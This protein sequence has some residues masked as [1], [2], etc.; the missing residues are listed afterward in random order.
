MM[1]AAQDFEPEEFQRLTNFLECPPNKCI[2]SELLQI[3]YKF[4]SNVQKSL[5]SELSDCLMLRRLFKGLQSCCVPLVTF[6]QALL[7]NHFVQALAKTYDSLLLRDYDKQDVLS[8]LLEL[9]FLIE[10][11]SE[12]PEGKISYGK[13][14]VPR[15]LVLAPVRGNAVNLQRA[16]METLCALITR[17]LENQQAV[18]D[19]VLDCY[20]LF[21]VFLPK[22][23]D[24]HLQASIAEIL[25]RL[26]RRDAQL[27]DLI[28]DTASKVAILNIHNM[29]KP[30]LVFEL[31]KFV[32][33]LNESTGS[34]R[35]VHSFLVDKITVNGHEAT[36]E[37]K[38]ID[39]G[40]SHISCYI[41]KSGNDEAHI[42]DLLYQDIIKIHRCSLTDLEIVIQEKCTNPYFQQDVADHLGQSSIHLFFSPED[43]SVII[44]SVIPQIRKLKRQDFKLTFHDQRDQTYLTTPYKSPQRRIGIRKVS[45]GLR[46]PLPKAMAVA[47]PVAQEL[48]QDV[49]E[50]LNT[51]N[52]ENDVVNASD[53]KFKQEEDRQRSNVEKGQET[54]EITKQCVIMVKEAQMKDK[55]VVASNPREYGA[56]KAEADKDQYTVERIQE[57]H[58][59]MEQRAII[60][61]ETQTNDTILNICNQVNCGAKAHVQIIHHEPPLPP[62]YF[63][64]DIT[65]DSSDEMEPMLKQKD[66][67]KEKI[68]DLSPTVLKAPKT[69]E[70]NAKKKKVSP[71]DFEHDSMPI[72]ME[73]SLE[74]VKFSTLMSTKKKP[75]RR[76]KRIKLSSQQLAHTLNLEPSS[77]QLS[78][79]GQQSSI[80]DR[81]VLQSKDPEE[82]NSLD[83]KDV[84]LPGRNIQVQVE[85][86]STTV[87]S[88]RTTIFQFQGSESKRPKNGVSDPIETDSD[89]H[90]TIMAK[91]FTVPYDQKRT[92]LARYKIKKQ[93][94]PL[95]Q[96]ILMKTSCEYQ[97]TASKDKSGTLSNLQLRSALRSTIISA[98]GQTFGSMVAPNKITP[99]HRQ[100]YSKKARKDK[101]NIEHLGNKDTGP[102][103][104]RLVD[105]FMCFGPL[106][107]VPESPAISSPTVK[108]AFM[109][110]EK[111][112]SAESLPFEVEEIMYCFTEA[113]TARAEGSVVVPEILHCARR[114]RRQRSSKKFSSIVSS[115]F[116]DRQEVATET[117]ISPPA[118]PSD[119]EENACREA[120][121]VT[122]YE[123]SSIDGICKMVGRLLQKFRQ[124]VRVQA[125]AKMKQILISTSEKALVEVQA[126]KSKIQDDVD[127]YSKVCKQKF[128]KL[129]FQLADQKKKFEEICH[130]FKTDC[131]TLLHLWNHFNS[132]TESTEIELRSLADKQKITHKK[133]LAHAHEASQH[134]MAEA[135]KELSTIR[136][137]AQDMQG[138]RNLLTDAAA[139][140]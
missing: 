21:K 20:K 119:E 6:P 81:K 26:S 116:D 42:C 134:Y 137:A 122:P 65:A 131:E 140:I 91:P 48:L 85:R 38:W 64:R 108:K 67:P 97:K 104:R 73:E 93:R 102:H 17:S 99:D 115:P 16:V 117:E 34:L 70:V 33:L 8:T 39:F 18:L 68:E 86:N 36:S 88:P 27:L 51:A 3:L 4:L 69:L 94:A 133:L 130:K 84:S 120:E 30:D 31:R 35:S 54:N 55:I 128:Q 50:D 62:L 9:L 40:S 109:N 53:N 139:K 107:A 58:E 19:S 63:S 23:G 28:D 105:S 72:I 74:E 15:L 132:Q 127:E 80:P 1:S 12:H 78:V 46:V 13:V 114:G 45:I 43:L 76:N 138:L 14:F 52:E 32:N 100:S 136:K 111:D 92:T 29:K 41:F 129:E 22:C 89:K 125:Q 56:G 118:I 87:H 110:A 75:N 126:V 106:A 10:D 44:F 98:H 90:Q 2:S 82:H 96:N 135:E 71:Y 79:N 121:D 124:K 123:D 37:E 47:L 25:Y 57:T 60:A 113:K 24:F 49:I 112:D 95:G 103:P 83:E 101:A 59:I 7:Q 5:R 66:V 61:N 77:C 11:I